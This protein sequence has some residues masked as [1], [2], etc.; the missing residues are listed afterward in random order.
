LSS[1]VGALLEVKTDFSMFICFARTATGEK[2]VW[3]LSFDN[4]T[5]ALQHVTS[6][7]IDQLTCK[8]HSRM[9]PTER[10]PKPSP[11]KLL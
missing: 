2:L 8:H 11:T 10:L 1:D 5:L 3:G 9:Q 6:K 7:L 4:V